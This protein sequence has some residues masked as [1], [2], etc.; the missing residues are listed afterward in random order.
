[1]NILYKIFGSEINQYKALIAELQ[2]QNANKNAWYI[3]CE[4]S[5][6]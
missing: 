4:Q 5:V 2:R 3:F 6:T 1:M